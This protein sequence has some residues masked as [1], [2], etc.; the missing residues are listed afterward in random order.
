M[1]NLKKIG[2]RVAALRTEADLSQEG[3]AVILGVARSTLAG[4]ET[5]NDRGGI[6]TMVA[7]ADHFKVPMDWL[8]GRVVPAGGPLAG[9]FVDDLDELAWLNFWRSISNEDRTA[10]VKL[11]Q[12]D[13]RH[14]VL[15][16][17]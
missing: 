10:V 17:K 13:N 3:L 9:Q 11:L 15:A 8:L 6:A 14:R 12:V 16:T 4:I 5:G 7:I 1:T 2:Q